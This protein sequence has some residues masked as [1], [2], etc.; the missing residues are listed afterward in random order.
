M[1]VAFA[2]DKRFERPVRSYY[3]WAVA[4]VLLF[5]LLV[6]GVWTW[7]G[8]VMLGAITWIVMAALGLFLAIHYER[9]EPLN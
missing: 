7:S 1:A 8:D 6:A 2:F 4:S 3:R 9:T 5:T